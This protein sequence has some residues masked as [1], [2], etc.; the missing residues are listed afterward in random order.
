[1]RD[2]RSKARLALFFLVRATKGGKTTKRRNRRRE[3]NEVLYRFV[4]HA[5]SRDLF[6]LISLFGE[7][8]WLQIKQ[9]LGIGQNTGLIEFEEGS[10]AAAAVELLLLNQ[11][12][13]VRLGAPRSRGYLASDP[14]FFFTAKDQASVRY[15]RCGWEWID[16]L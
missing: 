3:K 6:L 15:H 8:L 12:D 10:G 16:R 13:L 4:A 5:A 11:K 1:M 7:G 9:R 14:R 2:A